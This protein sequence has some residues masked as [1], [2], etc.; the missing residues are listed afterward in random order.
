VS[1]RGHSRLRRLA[2]SIN[3]SLL[4][5]WLEPL[6]AGL[7]GVALFDAHTHI[8]SNDPDGARLTREQLIDILA[9]LDARGVVFAMHEPG[10]YREAND[11][12]LEE[13]ARSD[14]RLVPFCRLDPNDGAVAEAARCVELGARGIKLHPRSDGF[15]MGSPEARKVF[16]FAGAH[17]LP[18]LVHAGRGIPALGRHTLEYSE[19]FPDARII[20]AHAAVSD[21][22]WIWRH[23]PDHPN[24]F[25]DTSW[26]V[27]VDL[28]FLFSRVRPGQILFASDVP[29]G[30][31]AL[32]AI[33]TMR[34][35][36]Q[37]GLSPDQ[38]IAV[39]GAQLERLLAGEDPIDLG[40]APGPRD[41]GRD[42]VL[43][44]VYLYAMVALGRM[45][46]GAP[47]DEIIALA[48]LAASVEEDAPQAAACLT[49]R[50]LIGL[51]A[52]AIAEVGAKELATPSTQRL[53]LLS[54]LLLAATLAATPDVPAPQGSP[55][56]GATST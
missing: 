41:A 40:P 33:L 42:L 38:L 30:A 53:A 51:Q 22:S 54:P 35:G 50:E 23:M 28:T 39:C 43:E 47:A 16:E 34:C 52:E 24:V 13:A 55:V 7:P 4:R 46:A 32:N 6:L 10:S 20:L 8:G 26:W 37:A 15:L 18:V 49:L 56:G 29:Y 11:H 17:R 36:L 5:A 45:I 48:E 44:R 9:P 14:G 27:P 12:I 19:Q 25:I 31:P 3:E 2:A 21:L 1:A